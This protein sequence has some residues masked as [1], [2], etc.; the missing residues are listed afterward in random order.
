M[1]LRGKNKHLQKLTKSFLFNISIENKP[2]SCYYP[3]AVLHG[4]LADLSTR[5]LYARCRACCEGYSEIAYVYRA[6]DNLEYNG[7][8]YRTVSGWK[9]SSTKVT[10]AG[11]I[12]LRSRFYKQKLF[13][14]T[15]I[16]SGTVF[17]CKKRWF[18]QYPNHLFI[19]FVRR[20]YPSP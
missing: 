20:C 2:S 19:F 13:Y 4:E 11:V 12:I 7:V 16:G 3:I 1:K 8:R 18:G 10:L 15:S 6:V 5:T 9:H 17:L 14:F